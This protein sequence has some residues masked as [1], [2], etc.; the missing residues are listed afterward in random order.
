MGK[1]TKNK[2]MAMAMK[3]GGAKKVAKKSMKSKK[4]SKKGGMK[5]KAMKIST[6][7]KGKFRRSQVYFGRKVKTVG[8]LSKS[9][10]TLN[11]HGR[12]VSKRLSAKSKNSKFPKVMIAARKELNIK[13][14]C[15][16]GGK[17][18]RG[19]ALLKK[20]RSLYKKLYKK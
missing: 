4:S 7:A 12:I 6:I 19:Q 20:A 2:N 15:P 18:A 16:M 3:K 8:G 11:K 5:K 17:T 14:F 13:G 1:Q 10:L 9:D